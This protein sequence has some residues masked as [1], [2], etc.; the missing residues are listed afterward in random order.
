M[1]IPVLMIPIIKIKRLWDYS[2]FIMG[3]LY[4]QA[5]IFLSKMPPWLLWWQMKSFRT[6]KGQND[7]ATIL[8]LTLKKYF[9]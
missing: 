7:T 1:G 9:L 6:H 3:I 5:R 4:K 2:I 8:Q